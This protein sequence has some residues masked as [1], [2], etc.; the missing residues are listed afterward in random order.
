[1]SFVK[2]LVVN[3]THTIV[4]RKVS[5]LWNILV[6]LIRHLVF[7]HNS[8]REEFSYHLTKKLLARYFYRVMKGE[9]EA[10]ISHHI[11]KAKVDNLFVYYKSS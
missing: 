5:P 10:S 4:N 2:L 1:M 8:L 11:K 7:T 9:S 3:L 6:Q